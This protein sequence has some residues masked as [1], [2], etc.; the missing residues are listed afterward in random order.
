M[1][2]N[3]NEI[4]AN[5]WFR[6]FFHCLHIIIYEDSC[7]LF[8]NV[9]IGSK[10]LK[11]LFHPCFCIAGLISEF[12]IFGETSGQVK[13]WKMTLKFLLLLFFLF[14][15]CFC[16]NTVQW[17][18][19]VVY[20]FTLIFNQKLS[21]QNS[22]LHFLVGS[23]RWLHMKCTK[24]R[25]MRCRTAKRWDRP[26]MALQLTRKQLCLRNWRWRRHIWF[27]SMV[28]WL[29]KV[30]LQNPDEREKLFEINQSAL[31]HH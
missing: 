9:F 8:I 2:R 13:C 1:E 22:S 10:C 7:S 24:Q 16:S 25:W 18:V 4:E 26:T 23:E 27:C 3:K 12:D 31:A 15:F 29:H 6:F 17:I 11:T 14:W 30:R 28:N 21:A 5:F 19:N 20:I